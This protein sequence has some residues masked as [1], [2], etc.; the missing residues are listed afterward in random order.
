MIDIPYDDIP[1]DLKEGRIKYYKN[2]IKIL[3]DTNKFSVTGDIIITTIRSGR[4]WVQLKHNKYK[5]YLNIV[6]RK[7]K[8]ERITNGSI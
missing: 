5:E 4:W 2:F 7:E 1:N 3:E 6:I 8:L